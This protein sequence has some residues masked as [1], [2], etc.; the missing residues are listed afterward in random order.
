MTAVQP[1]DPRA[2]VGRVDVVV[3]VGLALGLVV[4]AIARLIVSG[5]ADVAPDDAR[6][7]FVGLSTLDGHG[8]VTP[9]GNLFLLRS[10]IYGIALAA[11]RWLSADGPVGG[12]RVVAAALSLAD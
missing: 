2:L 10:P 11:G 1:R 8:S 9:S 6:Y 12:A 3:V 4:V 5:W 7:V